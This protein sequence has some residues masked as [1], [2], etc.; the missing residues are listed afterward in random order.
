MPRVYQTPDPEVRT[1]VGGAARC[2]STAV[3]ADG[4]DCIACFVRVM[5]DR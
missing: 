3:L 4:I 5:T 2:V 1:P